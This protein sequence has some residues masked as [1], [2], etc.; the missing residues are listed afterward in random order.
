[1]QSVLLEQLVNHARE[2]FLKNGCQRGETAKA[3]R[4]RS[5]PQTFGDDGDPKVLLASL[6]A[7]KILAKRQTTNNVKSGQVEPHGHVRAAV[8]LASF[9][10]FLDKGVG[11]VRDQGLLGFECAIGKGTG[12][13]FSHFGVVLG[14]TLADYG[15]RLGGEIAA[16][17]ELAL[18]ERADALSRAVNVTP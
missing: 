5:K 13:V 16:V 8:G 4:E 1:M 6:D 18:D 15:Q 7:P 17:V 9:A 3:I 11:A 14:I 12:Q 10:E 2:D